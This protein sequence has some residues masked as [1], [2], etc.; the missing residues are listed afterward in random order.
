MGGAIGLLFYLAYAIGVSFYIIGFSTEVQQSW[1]QFSNCDACKI[2]NTTYHSG[3]FTS[4]S[5][6][7]CVPGTLFVGTVSWTVAVIG[8]VSLAICL[9]ISLNGAGSF[10][11]MNVIFFAIQMFSIVWG[12]FP[13]NRSGNLLPRFPVSQMGLPAQ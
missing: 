8:T 10:A 1:P 12:E 13:L 3:N 5:P 2:G 9:A 7:D 6:A 11:K 4:C